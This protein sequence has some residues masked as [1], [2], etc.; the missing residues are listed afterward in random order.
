MIPTVE[1]QSSGIHWVSI[2][3]SGQHEGD[4]DVVTEVSQVWLG[5]AGQVSLLEVEGIVLFLHL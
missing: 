3:L 4:G 5:K 1:A 2:G